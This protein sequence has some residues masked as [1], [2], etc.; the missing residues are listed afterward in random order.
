VNSKTSYCAAGLLLLAALA[1]P[2]GASADH[3]ITM[4][5]VKTNATA[6]GTTAPPRIDTTVYWMSAKSARVDESNSSSFIING[7]TGMMYMLDH[8][9]KTSQLIEPNALNKLIEAQGGDDSAA[10][11]QAKG[12]MEMMKVKA[13]VTPTDETKKIG[14]Y[15]CKKWIYKIEIAMTTTTTEAWVSDEVPINYNQFMQLSQSMKAFLPGFQEAAKEL[16]KM[17]G[18]IVSASTQANFQGYDIAS[19]STLLAVEEVETTADMFVV[20][21]GYLETELPIPGK[22]PSKGDDKGQDQGHSHQGNK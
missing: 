18:F 6:D 4:E 1:L 19:V 14:D 21:E 3:K 15:N 17:G 16:E 22:S 12:M 9:K 5:I 2:L 11:A 20:P 7:E 10:V 13:A 8:K